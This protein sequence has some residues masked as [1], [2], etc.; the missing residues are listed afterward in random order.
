M[1]Q[2][3]KNLVFILGF[4]DGIGSSE[5]HVIF[6]VL[7]ELFYVKTKNY[8]SISSF[9]INLFKRNSHCDLEYKYNK[10]ISSQC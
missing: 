9:F 3:F 7:I 5:F 2:K 6:F 8:D 4:P 10:I 1:I